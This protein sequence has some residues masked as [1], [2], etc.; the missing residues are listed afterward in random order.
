MN[1]GSDSANAGGGIIYSD[2]IR[3]VKRISC[4]FGCVGVG[5]IM[6]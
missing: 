3:N 4:V 6:M 1:R 5:V 2:S